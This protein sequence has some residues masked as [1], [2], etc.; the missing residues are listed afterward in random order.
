MTE[1]IYDS[2]SEYYVYEDYPYSN[3]ERND[4]KLNKRI[5][6]LAR[7][8]KFY[9]KQIQNVFERN[10]G[11]MRQSHQICVAKK[12][13]KKGDDYKV[14]GFIIYDGNCL[15]GRNN[16]MLMNLEYWLVDKKF[17]GQGIGKRLYEEMEKEGDK[18]GLKNYCVMYDKTNEKLMK[19]Y[20]SL[21]YG[22]IPRY[23]G[24]DVVNKESD[25]HIKVYKIV[26]ASYRLPTKEE[27]YLELL[28]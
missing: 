21:G 15:W 22:V 7:R 8:H 5:I 27:R 25:K 23:D 2:P 28:Q 4:E 17:Q 12:L 1:I 19:L 24:C 26:Y 14:V 6:S 16:R 10:S 11:L 3:G 13:N 9:T 18:W 20:T